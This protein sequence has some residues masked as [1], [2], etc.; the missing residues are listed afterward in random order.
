MWKGI[1]PPSVPIIS[2][3]PQNC[4]D[5]DIYL[6]SFLH[7]PFRCSISRSV[8]VMIGLIAGPLSLHAVDRTWTGEFSNSWA[9]AANWTPNNAIGGA[10]DNLFFGGSV[11]QTILLDRD[12]SA[13][14]LNFSGTA[15]FTFNPGLGGAL[16]VRRNGIEVLGTDQIVSFNIW[17]RPDD[18]T[19]AMRVYNDGTL[20]INS[21]FQVTSG[22]TITFDGAGTTSINQLSRRRPNYD[23][24][25]VKEGTG[26]LI[27]TSSYNLPAT[28]DVAATP[29]T[30]AVDGTIGY[31]TGNVTVNNGSLFV[32]NAT[33]SATGGAS[34]L[35]NS[36][37][38][39]G[40][41]GSITGG[42]SKNITVAS[43]LLLVGNTHG[44]G[45]TAQDLQLGSSSAFNLGAASS[46][47]DVNLHGTLQFD[48]MGA[49]SLLPVDSASY[50][51]YNTLANND[52]L[53]ISTTGDVSL[54]NSI[55]Q[56]AAT[57][58]AGWREG[59]TWKLMDWSNYAL[60]SFSADNLHLSTSYFNG[61][62]LIGSIV[63][64][65]AG[66]GYYVTVSSV[67]EPDR[68]L[69]LGLAG[70][71]FLLRRRRRAQPV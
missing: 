60:S 41:T 69:L 2:L 31:I 25:I 65:G 57:N 42:D 12:K 64:S 48:I 30:P 67:P 66:A 8:C 7:F 10:A 54:D 34:V 62:Y 55:I 71:G 36:G 26:N 49:G 18:N 9:D 33:G 29:E 63:E 59:E 19:G 28:P 14:S 56:V 11:D 21:H 38:R 23:M 1:Y 4:G 20:N 37:G 70:V 32:R 35:I 43:G 17:V 27:L 6:M 47:V 53:R 5:A 24:N 15:D 61:W 45:G 52:I 44:T 22:H 40:G 16:G 58:T 39:L 13:L 3:K 46:N 68:M 50:A 51:S